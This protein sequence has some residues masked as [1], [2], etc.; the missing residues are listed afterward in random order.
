M[1]CDR[2]CLGAG[3][4]ARCQSHYSYYNK[5]T[6]LENG[7]G[8]RSYPVIRTDKAYTNKNQRRRATRGNTWT[9]E[10][11]SRCCF[12]RDDATENAESDDATDD[13]LSWLRAVEGSGL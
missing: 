3:F 7:R 1:P 4:I 11:K 12:R 10:K 5:P 13:W 9:G 2:F 6:E 8:A